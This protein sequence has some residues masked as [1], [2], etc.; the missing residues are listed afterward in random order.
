M[1]RTMYDAVNAANIPSSA[2]TVAG[3]IDTI[4]IPC[5]TAADWA[6]FPKAVKVRIAKKPTTNDGHVLDVETGDATPAQAPGWVAMRRRAGVDPSVYCNAST[7]PAV[8]AAFT[9][10]GV[11]QPHY[12]IAEY[13]NN[14]TIPAGAVAKQ[15]R[16]TSTLDYSVVADTWPGVDDTQEDNVAITEAD[17]QL[18]ADK[19]WAEQ[20]TNPISGL[21]ETTASLLRYLEQRESADINRSI[22]AEQAALN[23]AIQQHA[24]TVTADVDPQALI[25]A[26]LPEKVVQALLAAVSSAANAANPAS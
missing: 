18:V 13:D 23:T 26:G 9:A 20:E 10:A 4:H 16:S 1:T 17:A 25:A 7:W 12:W 5:W 8:R 22:T 24:T 6:R 14:P 3:Y 15:Y 21:K 19:V 11:A 2:T